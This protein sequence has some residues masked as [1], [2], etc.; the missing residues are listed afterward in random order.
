MLL[1][2]NQWQLLAKIGLSKLI[3]IISLTK[4]DIR[5]RILFIHISINCII[6]KF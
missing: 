6:F 4:I 5:I 2:A 1:V 3:I